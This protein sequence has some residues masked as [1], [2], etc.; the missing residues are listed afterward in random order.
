MR[1][2]GHLTMSCL[3]RYIRADDS[4]I[5]RAVNALDNYMASNSIS[6]EISNSVM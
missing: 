4:T 1:I 5:F 6:K 2:S 3:F